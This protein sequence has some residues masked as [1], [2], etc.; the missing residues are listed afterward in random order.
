MVDVRIDA[1][2]ARFRPLRSRVI[3]P[4]FFYMVRSSAPDRY[5]QWKERWSS[6]DGRATLRTRFQVEGQDK[7]RS[8]RQTVEQRTPQEFRDLRRPRSGKIWSAPDE[9]LRRRDRQQVEDRR[10][11][12]DSP[13]RSGVQRQRDM[14]NRDDFRRDNTVRNRQE[15][16]RQ[17]REQRQIEERQIREQR[18]QRD[19]G[20][21]ERQQRDRGQAD[22]QTRE[23]RDERP[24]DGDRQTRERSQDR[25]ADRGSRDDRGRGND[26]GHRDNGDRA[27]GR[28]RDRNR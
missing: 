10:V 18:Q 12:P 6:V 1:S 25:P 16:Q 11:R 24:P 28:G 26:N 19:Q 20:Q 4:R 9:V 7:F 2:W 14:R 23:R 17:I 21:V 13:D 15:E 22:R 8:R 5:R 3:R 27:G